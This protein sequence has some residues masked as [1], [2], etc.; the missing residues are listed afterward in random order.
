MAEQNL[1]R[2]K[3]DWCGDTQEFDDKPITPKDA[4][5]VQGW[6]ILVRVFLVND[7]R[8]PVQK[9][10]CKDSCAVN[11]LSQGMLDLPQEIKDSIAEQE[12]Q[13]ILE[14]AAAAEGAAKTAEA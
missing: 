1:V 11:I 8:Y 2:R 10:A 6:A 4:L 12:K 14:M 5:R 3:C 7:Q 13:R 9:H